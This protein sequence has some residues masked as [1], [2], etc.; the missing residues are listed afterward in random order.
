MTYET[1]CLMKPNG[2]F[3]NCNKYQV[4]LFTS[5]HYNPT[6]TIHVNDSMK[7]AYRTVQKLQIVGGSKV[8]IKVKESQ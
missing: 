3:H 1:F 5:I 6:Q 4:I 8:E 7:L 2:L